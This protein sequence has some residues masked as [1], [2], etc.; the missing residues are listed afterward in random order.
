MSV[1]KGRWALV[2]G[3]SSGLGSDFARGLAARG[4]NLILV[5]RREG[6]LREL[7]AEVETQYG[8]AVRILPA[9]LATPE[10]PVYVKATVQE[11]E[12]SVDVL[13]NNAGIGICRPFTEISWEEELQMLQLDIVALVHLTKLFVPGMVERG[14]GYV[15]QVSSVAAFQPC[16]TFA[17]YGGAKSFVLSFSEA[18]AHEVHKSGVRVCTVCPGPAETEFFGTSGQKFT[19]YQKAMMM[20]SRDVTE[21]GIKAMLKGRRSRTPGF[22]NALAAFGARFAPRRVLAALAASTLKNH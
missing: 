5:A 21:A 7:S 12:I 4:C 3:A 16:P 15:L 11:W 6:K 2:T 14:F 13:V 8:C 19:F 20:K 1:L 10:G 17:T 18:L 22:L 9:D